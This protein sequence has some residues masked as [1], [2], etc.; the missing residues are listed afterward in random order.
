MTG[1]AVRQV[2]LDTAER[3]IREEIEKI[4]AAHSE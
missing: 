4:K 1:E 2:V 3:L